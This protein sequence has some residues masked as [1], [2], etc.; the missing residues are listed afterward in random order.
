MLKSLK[1]IQSPLKKEPPHQLRMPSIP[2]LRRSLPF[3]FATSVQA[4]SVTDPT[5]FQA[6]MRE[7]T[8]LV[9]WVN[10]TNK[11]AHKRGAFEGRAELSRCHCSGKSHLPPG[12]CMSPPVFLDQKNCSWA[13]FVMGTT[14]EQKH[15]SAW[16]RHSQEKVLS[17]GRC[18]PGWEGAEGIGKAGLLLLS[19]TISYSGWFSTPN[20][21][22]P[23]VLV[24]H[25]GENILLKRGL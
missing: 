19:S 21:G 18:L 5:I 25:C 22:T 9:I 2:Q 17:I 12:A 20:P 1:K 23:Q 13:F 16:R 8:N 11:P 7:D 24:H 10:P 6:S 3:P 15:P 4:R 14:W